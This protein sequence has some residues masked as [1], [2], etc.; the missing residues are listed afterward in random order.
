M[1]ADHVG[2]GVFD[3]SA[4]LDQLKQDLL[5][6]QKEVDK[7]AG[8]F[9][10]SA[11]KVGASLTRTLTPAAAA[12][13]AFGAV[14]F[15]QWDDGLD[16]IRVK[17]GLTGQALEDMDG[18]MKDLA[19]DSTVGMGDIGSM[20]GDLEARTKMTGPPLE[21]LAKRFVDLQ[22]LG[23]PADIDAATR[24]MAG[25][26]VPASDMAGAMDL[27]FR[28]SQAAGVPIDTLFGLV[29]QFA[30]P[31]QAMGLGFGQS[32]ALMAQLSSSGVETEKAMGGM[33][34]AMANAAKK[35]EDPIA[36]LSGVV[37]AIKGA[38]T[39]G[40]ALGI[41]ADK[42]G[43]KAGPELATAIRSG[44]LELDGMF[45]SVV[46]GQDTIHKA[47][48][49]SRDWAEQ[50]AIL[51]NKAEV[52]VGPVGQILT[53]VGGLGAGLGPAISGFTKVGPLIQGLGPMIG[54]AMPWLLA[55]AAAFLIG[56]LIF[57]H[58][59][60]IKKW[61]G[62]ILSWFKD[63]LGPAIWNIF[64]SYVNFITWPWRTALNFIADLW[65]KTLGGFTFKVPA[66]V[67][68]LGGKG[69]TFPTM[70]HVPKLDIGGEIMGTGIVVAHK[71][72]VVV[73][74]KVA[75][76]LDF[77]ALGGTSGGGHDE[78]IQ[79]VVDGRVLTEVVRNRQ[80][81]IDRRNGFAA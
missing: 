2:A 65:N 71:G 54:T 13:G 66:W 63:T 81:D 50:L 77:G 36:A 76:Q 46:N 49:D 33:T 43:A 57:D 28:A 72:E 58:W 73:P 9:G 1:A 35:G 62:G 61:F 11:G 22:E 55:I 44:K 69:F 41:A 27:V 21:E 52:V 75:H 12:I 10:Q 64:K 80:S 60:T 17:T 30:A 16:S 32:V 37:A 48:T 56:K 42:F 8:G 6:A 3:L 51:K 59:D 29:D 25:F 5:G 19:K 78:I 47:T 40:E 7:S 45:A 18:I 53:V 24:A 70:P 26:R 20:L 67:P 68:G 39:E 14:A 34:K 23:I 74:A 15:K 31:L 79:V 4:P 38:S